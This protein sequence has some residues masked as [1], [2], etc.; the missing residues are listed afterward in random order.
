MT[1]KFDPE[2]WQRLVSP[3]RYALLDPRAFLQRIGVARGSTVADL[4]A[5]P[6]FFTLPLAEEVGPRGKVFAVDAAPQMLERLRERGLPAQVEAVLGGEDGLPLP[7]CSV[8]LA[9]LAF[10]L[11]ELEDPLGFLNEVRRVLQPGG[12]LVVLEWVPHE[13]E[14]G[15]PL[16]ERLPRDAAAAMLT[17]GG[18][19]VAEE[20]DANRSN[21]FLIARPVEQ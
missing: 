19:R 2:N 8:A 1:R 4:G 14:L 21:Y 17:E 11:H 13:E 16:P 9:L 15:P 20:D 7:D 6:G 18:F 3:E 12:R 10:V 5:G